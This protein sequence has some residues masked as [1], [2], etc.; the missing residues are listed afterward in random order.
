LARPALAA[1]AFAAL[2][3]ASSCAGSRAQARHEV[4]PVALEEWPR[5]SGPPRLQ[6]AGSLTEARVRGGAR[7]W[8]KTVFLALTGS[9]DDQADAGPL[10]RP[11]DVEPDA[12]GGYIVADPDLA[13]VLRYGADERLAGELKCEGIPWGAP[14]ALAADSGGAIYVADA[15]AGAVV[16]W[17]RG[18]CTAFHPPGLSRPTGVAVAG[19]RLFITDPPSHR[20]LILTTDG[21]PIA[22]IGQRGDG[23]DQFNYPTDVAAAPDGSV[24]VIDALNFR[25]VHLAS[26]GRWLG[27][28]GSEGDEGAGLARP[29]CV[30]VD[31]H[32]HVYVTD[33]QR[34][35]IL[36]FDADGTFR[37]AFGGTGSEPG[38]FA[39]PSGISSRG[40]RLMVADSQNRRVQLLDAPGELP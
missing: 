26:D 18:G 36:L 10:V 13:A 19:G 4:G 27:A 11:F 6:Y 24:F 16:R 38:R 5:P 23:P 29:K 9:P 22:A 25:V 15:G 40:S 7:G 21:S 17:T 14:M 3:V 8:W 30:H 33:A 12:E 37:A 35:V 2:S 31:R 28:F 20:V 34:D 32:G 1:A 39:H